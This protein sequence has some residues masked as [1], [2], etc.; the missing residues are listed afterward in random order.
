MLGWTICLAVVVA[1]VNL[2]FVYC[3]VYS[4]S[5][6]SAQDVCDDIEIVFEVKPTREQAELAARLMLPPTFFCYKNRQG[7]VS[8]EDSDGK[9]H[10]LFKQ[11]TEVQF[12]LSKLHFCTLSLSN[13]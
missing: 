7:Y 10:T 12:S 6:K 11:M 3:S 1:L 5:E 13:L 2:V 9:I 4:P 8:E